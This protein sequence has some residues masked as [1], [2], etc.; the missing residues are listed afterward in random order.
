MENQHSGQEKLAAALSAIVFFIPLLMNVKT[1]FV[2]KYMKQGFLI[3]VVELILA[4]ISSLIWGMMGITGLLN[5][6]CVL[7]SLWLAFQAFS[8]KEYTIPV[9]IENA[10][11]LIQALSIGKWFSAK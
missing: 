3:N 9:L 6:I 11:K 5:F 4:V 1:S 2:V 7:T 10:D 8:G